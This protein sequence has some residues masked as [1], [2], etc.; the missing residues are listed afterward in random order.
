MVMKTKAIFIIAGFAILFCLYHAAE[1]MILFKN[2]PAGFL[3]FQALFFLAAWAIAKAQFKQ[4]L[5]AWGLDT[6]KY[7]LKHLA[8]G[9]LMGIILYALTFT[10][11][12]LTGAEKIISIPSAAAMA[13]PLGLFIFGN[14]FSSVSEDIF[15]RGYVYKHANEKCSNGLLVIISAGIYLLN[16]IYRLSDG[17]VTCTYLFMLGV[18]YIIPLILTKRLWFTG[19]MHWAG[20][21]FFYYTHEVIKTGDG[22]ASISP[23]YILVLCCIVIIPVNY[24]LL[25]QFKMT[26]A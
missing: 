14:F 22:T 19:G 3:G 26:A 1:Y 11:S 13:A 2:S 5:G 21:C 8:I 6:G 16:H 20:N 25:R 12:L 17:I 10:I 24:F 23:N 18:V 4:G 9:M 15:T 7:L